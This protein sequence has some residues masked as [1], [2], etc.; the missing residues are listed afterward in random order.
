MN[1]IVLVH[2]IAQQYKGAQSL[3]SDWYPALCDGLS[4]T[5]TR[6]DADRVAVAFYGDLF[7][8][9]GHRGIGAIDLEA[10]DVADGL[11]SE[12]LAAWWQAA[13]QQESRV[14][15]PDAATRL[16]TPY[17]A[18]RALLALSHST[19]FTGLSEH[20]LIY[21]ARQV[22]RYLTE[23]N[24][25]RQIQNRLSESV[26]KSTKVIVAHS[27]GSVVAYETLHVN[28]QWSD[29]TLVTLGSPLGV[30]NLIFDRLLPPSVAGVAP[31]PPALGDWI[32]IADRGDIVALVKQ[33]APRFGERINDI[34]V[35]NGSK[36]HDIRP[37]L[38]A[39][40]TGEA[41]A[42]GLAK[43]ST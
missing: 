7:R 5:R 14:T 10:S 15:A 1:D 38:T 34:P 42:Q 16:R 4:A 21:S 37:Y 17:A 26:T 29:L 24:L 30:P 36:A 31:W 40:E 43:I 23:E 41:I 32:N 28:P 20:L 9:S 2:G 25:R 3:L 19:F 6:L 22:R 35:D 12:L 11:E 13:A 39:R 27:L 8:P 33:L 18:Q